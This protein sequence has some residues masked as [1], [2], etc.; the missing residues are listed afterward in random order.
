MSIILNSLGAV[1]EIHFSDPSKTD[2]DGLTFRWKKFFTVLCFLLSSKKKS[3]GPKIEAAALFDN[4][5]IKIL[6]VCIMI[7]QNPVFRKKIFALHPSER[8]E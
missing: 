2:L 7:P 6:S 4:L 5:I 3:N 1:Q 8:S